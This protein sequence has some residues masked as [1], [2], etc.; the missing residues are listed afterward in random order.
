LLKSQIT[1]TKLQINPNDRNSKSQTF[2]SLNIGIWNLFVTW[3]LLFG[4][5]ALEA[6]NI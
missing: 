3:V 6:W 4:A 2:W 5:L 1:S